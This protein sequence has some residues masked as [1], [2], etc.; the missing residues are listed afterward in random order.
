MST[1]IKNSLLGKIKRICLFIF[2]GRM[3]ADSEDDLQL[4]YLNF[5]KKSVAA[6][7]ATAATVPTVIVM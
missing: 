7:A 6:I 5:H 4:L 1:I 2:F 3:T